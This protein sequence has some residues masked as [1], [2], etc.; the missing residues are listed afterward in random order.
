MFYEHRKIFRASRRHW[1]YD[2]T[3]LGCA[4]LLNPYHFNKVTT[5]TYFIQYWLGPFLGSLLGAG[6]YATLKQYV[7]LYLALAW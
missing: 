4:C 3:S 2:A 6:F 5:S 1:F 7:P